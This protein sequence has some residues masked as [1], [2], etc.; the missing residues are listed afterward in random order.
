M[1]N[2]PDWFLE[3]PEASQD[4][5]Y[6]VGSSFS[7]DLQNAVRK[8][9]L[10]ANYEIAQTYQQRVSGS[11]RAFIRESGINEQGGVQAE[12]ETVIDKLVA[13]ADVSGTEV[14]QKKVLQEGT[15]F[16]AYV[17]ARYKMGTNNLIK[18][19][20]E[21]EHVV[22]STRQAADDAYQEL[23]SRVEQARKGDNE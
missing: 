3:P 13:E 10:Q 12:S 11:E 23:E 21:R 16:R 18:Q 1:A 20:V 19:E 8:A 7:A 15:G 6:G 5:I 9:S 4:A 14:V 22:K 2:V 17:L